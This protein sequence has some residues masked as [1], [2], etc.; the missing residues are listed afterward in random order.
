VVARL[1]A[2][3]SEDQRRE[4]AAAIAKRVDAQRKSNEALARR[5]R[6]EGGPAIDMLLKLA[7][8]IAAAEMADTRLNAQI[9]DD[10]DRI[11]GADRLARYRPPAPRETVSESEVELWVFASNG[12]LVGAQDEVIDRCDGTGYLTGSP[13]YR[14]QCVKRR[15]RSID[16]LEAE[17]RQYYEPFYS[18]L[19]LPGID[20]P[21]WSPR[22]G[23]SP[24][25]ILEALVRRGQ[26]SERQVLTE[27]VPMDAW[28]GVAAG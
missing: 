26:R 5:I 25:A 27:L 14:T 24:A 23:T 19:Q 22:K 17:P 18:E 20:G 13:E 8:D 11:V 2:A 6:E 28:T 9:P 3:A 4:E 16:Y 10:A 1:E 7:H 12:N 21:A 15:F